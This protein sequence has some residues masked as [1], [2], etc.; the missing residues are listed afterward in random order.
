MHAAAHRGHLRQQSLK[1]RNLLA[2]IGKIRSEYRREAQHQG[3][4][5]GVMI[6]LRVHRKIYYV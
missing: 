5:Y 1:E 2:L 6:D 3:V 4:T